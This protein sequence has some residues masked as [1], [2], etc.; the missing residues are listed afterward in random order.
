MAVVN[1]FTSSRGTAAVE[2]LLGLLGSEQVR[3]L[4]DAHPFST[5]F[6]ARDRAAVG[7]VLTD[8]Q[9]RRVAELEA[10]ALMLRRHRPDWSAHRSHLSDLLVSRDKVGA[11]LFEL[12]VGEYLGRASK[13]R[14]RWARFN[15]HAPDWVADRQHLGVECHRAMSIE[16]LANYGKTL[17]EKAAQHDKWRGPLVIALGFDGVVPPNVV[18]RMHRDAQRYLPWMTRH[19]EVSAVLVFASQ[20]VTRAPVAAARGG[21]QLRSQQCTEIRNANAVHPIRPGLL[22]DG[23]EVF[24]RTFPGPMKSMNE[25]INGLT[26]EEK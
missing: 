17:S 18:Q 7:G 11:V 5:A 8:R 2:E 13:T 3:R 24:R 1:E 4:D 21:L 20:R 26:T 25:Q 15:E 10:I 19:R 6:A 12:E 9:A 22:G 23:P 16:K 14:W